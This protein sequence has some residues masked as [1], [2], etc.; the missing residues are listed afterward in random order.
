MKKKLL[1]SMR[2]LLVAVLLGVGASAW[3]EDSYTTLYEKTLSGGTAWTTDDIADWSGTTTKLSINANYGLYYDSN[4][5]DNAYKAFTIKENSKIKY[6]I[7]WY[8]GGAVGRNN[9]YEYL[10]F[11]ENLRIGHM[12]NNNNTSGVYLSTNHGTSYDAT[13]IYTGSYNTRVTKDLTIIFDTSTGEVESFVFDGVDVTDRISGA[14]DGT[15]NTLYM[16][17]TRGGSVTW[18]NPHGLVALKVSEC[19]QTVTNADY[20]VNYVDGG[21]NALKAAAVRNG[22]VGNYISL[23]ST[24]KDAIWVDTDDDEVVDTK[25]I[26]ASD[27]AST[28]EITNDGLASCNVVFNV[29]PTYSYS[30]KTSFGTTLA[31]GSTF[32][33]ETVSTPIPRYVMNGETFYVYAS[34]ANNITYSRSMTVTSDNQEETINYNDT[35]YDNVAYFA[36]AEDITG[37]TASNGGQGGARSSMCYGAYAEDNVTVTS[38]PAGKYTLTAYICGNSGTTFHF[39]AGN[40]SNEIHSIATTGSL[41]TTTSAEFNLVE[42]TDIVIGAAGNGGDAAKLID[43]IYIRR[44]GDATTS[45]SVTVSDAGWA[46][47]YTPYALDFSSLS[48]S[49]TA[50]TATCSES[51]VTLTAVSNVPA[52]TGVVLK[53]AA[54]TYNIPVIASSTTAKGDLLGST[55]AATAY[56]AYE[57]YTL[58]MLNKVDDKAQFVPVTSGEIAAGK[59]FLKVAGGNSSQARSLNVVFAGEATG[60]SQIANGIQNAENAVYNL[61]GQ[62]ISQP[63]KGLYIVNGKKVIIK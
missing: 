11:G 18:P 47:L 37:M 31:S 10:Q 41:T 8:F 54:N 19:E 32:S 22:V 48:E 63:T 35:G 28:T 40:T 49:L 55:T 36:E 60:I 2:V 7:T 53:G 57:G 43:F 17:F 4:Q 1:N 3:A 44:T 13:R 51:T 26:Y 14:L 24:D 61:S 21:G 45:E 34:A 5:T 27:N 50:Y 12:D 46:T 56:N 52:G 20:T 15:F 16:G 38:L 6:E 42:A 58:Y 25:Y 23:L 39:Y 62:R 33:G 59:A 9:N 30:F 29:A